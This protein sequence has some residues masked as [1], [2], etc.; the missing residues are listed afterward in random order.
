ML[1]GKKKNDCIHHQQGI[2]S[3]GG[4]AFHS[5]ENYNFFLTKR[6]CISLFK[7]VY[8]ITYMC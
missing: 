1:L 6:E 2:K 3:P 7:W 8:K 5:V 4:Y